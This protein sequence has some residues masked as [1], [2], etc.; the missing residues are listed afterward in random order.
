[1]PEPANK[2]IQYTQ[3]Y[4]HSLDEK[5]RVAVPFRWRTVEEEEFTLVVWPHSVGLFLRVLPPPQWKKLLQP[6]DNMTDDETKAATK[7]RIGVMSLCTKL[8]KAGRLAIPDDMT[9]HAG[10]KSQVVLLGS[11]NRFEIWS[12]E[13][14][15]E[16]E[17]KDG[18]ITPHPFKGFE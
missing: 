11:I 5:K 17:V 15:A 6:I 18:L 16:M 12:P 14:Y 4:R 10:I 13:R 9:A 2:E 3:T 8:D 1:M 7:R